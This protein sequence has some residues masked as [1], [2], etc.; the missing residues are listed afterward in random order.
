VSGV[1]GMALFGA[2]LGATI[3]G[4]TWLLGSPEP[5]IASVVVCAICG[6]GAAVAASLAAI[7]IARRARI[8]PKAKAGAAR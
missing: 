3:V 6:S 5:T 4:L 2:G 8:K 7:R 1:V